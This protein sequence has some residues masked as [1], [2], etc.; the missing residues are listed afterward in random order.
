MP[1]M[2]TMRPLILTLLLLC[3]L[4]S[5]PLWSGSGCMTA[6][7]ED[8]VFKATAT[9]TLTAQ[10]AYSAYLDYALATNASE[11]EQAR[12]KA[13]YDAFYTTVQIERKAVAA[14]KSGVE[15]NS[16]NMALAAVTSSSADVINLILMLLPPER[17]A[18]LVK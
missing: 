17:A 11:E 13:A 7:H 3:C 2:K 12:V 4:A 6:T 10:T 14:F 9:T 18:K 8:I 16:L 5:I 1:G 15:T